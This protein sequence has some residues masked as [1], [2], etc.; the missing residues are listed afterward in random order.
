MGAVAVNT[1]TTTC[2]PWICH[3]HTHHP[4]THSLATHQQPPCSHP[5]PHPIDLLSQPN[6]PPGSTPHSS[7]AIK[8]ST[9]EFR[10]VYLD[11]LQCLH[12]SRLIV[13]TYRLYL[14]KKSLS[15]PTLY[16]YWHPLSP[17]GKLI[18]CP[19]IDQRQRGRHCRCYA[20]SP[21]AS[22]LQWHPLPAGCLPITGNCLACLIGPTF[23]KTYSLD[24]KERLVLTQPCHYRSHKALTNTNNTCIFLMNFLYSQWLFRTS[25]SQQLTFNRVPNSEEHN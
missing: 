2:P 5:L 22:G 20:D 9:A 21:P 25:L 10:P 3:P 24:I 8:P 17:C 18:I 15:H 19:C 13:S 11:Y 7:P 4:T 14:Q 16:T 12:P 6:A 1:A 23:P